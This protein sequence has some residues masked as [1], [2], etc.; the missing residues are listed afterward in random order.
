MNTDAWAAEVS[1]Y[2]A[3]P[4]SDQWRWLAKLAF[5]LSV[6]ARDTYVVGGTGI[7]DPIRMRRFNEL[8]H[9][10]AGQLQSKAM[11]KEGCRMRN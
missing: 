10:V 6:L 11:G 9:R 1:R 7:A 2:C 5:L 4:A 3:T 8:A